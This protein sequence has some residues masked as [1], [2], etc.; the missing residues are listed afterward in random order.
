VNHSGDREY[1]EERAR[2]YGRAACG[3]LDPIE[4]EYEERL[5]WDAFRRLVPLHASWRV[6]DIGCG[7]GTWSRRIA[8]FGCRVT[9][10]DFSAEMIRMATPAER[11]EFIVGSAQDLALPD[12]SFDLAL[13]VTVLQHITWDSELQRA[14][15]NVRRMLKADGRFF[16][17]EYSPQHPPPRPA[18]A[19]HMQYRSGEEWVHLCSSA[20]FELTRDSGIRF[21]GHRVLGSGVARWR[22]LRNRKRPQ[23]TESGLE[24]LTGSERALSA[25]ATAVD[26]MA[27][28]IPGGGRFSDVKALVFKPLL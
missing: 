11:V 9:G 3:C 13:S 23:E 5:R 10:A 27:A 7:V 24:G 15:A 4:Y 16:V 21:I 2:R 19:S 28:R 1:W 12:R 8:A 20:G 25:V 6:L 26:L 14:L 22:R 17:I 18:G